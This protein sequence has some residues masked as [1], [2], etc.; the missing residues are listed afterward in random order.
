MRYSLLENRPMFTVILSIPHSVCFLLFIWLY[1]SWYIFYLSF[2]LLRYF[3]IKYFKMKIWRYFIYLY[4]FI[5]LSWVAA[6]KFLVAACEIYLPDQELNPGSLHWEHRILITK[7][8]GKNLTM[9]AL[10]WNEK[11]SQCQAKGG[12]PQMGNEVPW[13]SKILFFSVLLLFLCKD[14]GGIPG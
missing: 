4:L 6:C 2:I 5:W 11:T 13:T 1:L 7:P 10:S 3:K 9:G 8:P 14:G 12:L